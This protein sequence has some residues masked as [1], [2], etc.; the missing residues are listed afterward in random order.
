MYGYA[1]KILHV[2]LSTGTIK[3]EPLDKGFAREYIGG[4]GFGAKI[5]LDLIKDNLIQYIVGSLVFGVTLAVAFGI[6][7]YI[8]LLIFKKKPVLQEELVKTYQD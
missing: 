3:T 8:L 5:Y 7:T 1:G 2:N 4:L 6:L